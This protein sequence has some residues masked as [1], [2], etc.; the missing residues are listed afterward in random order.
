MCKE[1]DA[2]WDALREELD[3]EER[4]EPEEATGDRPTPV[5]E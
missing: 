5:A 3:T 2:E 1:L 4:S